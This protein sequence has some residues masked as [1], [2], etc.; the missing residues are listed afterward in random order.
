MFAEN[1]NEQK[2]FKLYS[3]SLRNMQMEYWLELEIYGSNIH[4]LYE[5]QR[6]IQIIIWFGLHYRVWD[7]YTY[8]IVYVTYSTSNIFNSMMVSIYISTKSWEK[9]IKFGNITTHLLSVFLMSTLPL[10]KWVCY[11]GVI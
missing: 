9:S 4:I 11:I 10:H 1:V 6:F 3:W 7:G 2:Y 5:S 8:N